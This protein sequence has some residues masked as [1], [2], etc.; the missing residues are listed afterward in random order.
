[1]N[2]NPAL[3]ASEIAALWNAYMQNTMAY[4]VIQHFATVNEDKDNNELIQNSLDACGF[5]IDGV[6]AIFELEKQAVP[7]GFTEEDVN[8][9]VSRIYSDLFALRYIKYMA[10]FGTAASASFLELLARFDVRDFFTNASNKFI[11]LYNEATDLL[12][13]K[14][15]FIRS[16]TMP[17]MEKT[18]YLQNESFLSGLLGRHRPLTAIEIAHICKNLETNSIGRTFLIGFAQTAQLP[19]V[20]TFMDRGS[21]IAEKQ[22]TIFREIFLEEGMPLPSTWDSTISKSTDTPFSDK[23]MM[24]H[25]LQLNMISV[26]AYGASIAGSM[27]VDLGAHYTRLLTEILQYSNDG[28]KFMIDKGW[29]EQPPQN[30]DREALKN[31]H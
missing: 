30:V 17:P 21:Q 28:V 23:L 2:H 25:T 22:E 1:M 12:L 5:V 24:F 11:C 8:L 9:K 14:G 20:R 29:I 26:T 15:A 7:I 6:K 3:T 27:R 18:E 19:E 10:A 4:R 31:R 13:K 16:P